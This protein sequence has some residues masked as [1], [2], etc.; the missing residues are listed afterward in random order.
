MA[1][2]REFVESFQAL[3]S[4]KRVIAPLSDLLTKLSRDAGQKLSH[5][6]SV[7]LKR[8][9]FYLGRV[10]RQTKRGLTR[11]GLESSWVLGHWYVVCSLGFV[12]QHRGLKNTTFDMVPYRSHDICI[13]QRTRCFEGNA[14][15]DLDCQDEV[16]HFTRNTAPKKV[17]FECPDWDNPQIKSSNKWCENI[18]LKLHSS[19]TNELKVDDLNM[20]VMA[21]KLHILKH[22]FL[23]HIFN[24]AAKKV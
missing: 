9:A 5:R 20:D 2:E 16:H 17:Q 13:Y 10:Y 8:S 24:S 6:E 22:E 14:L 12:P 7:R 4:D 19:K 11:D 1:E 21:K 3:D 15:S 18:H 23:A